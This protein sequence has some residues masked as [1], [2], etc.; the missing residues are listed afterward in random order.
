MEVAKN[1]DT[2]PL[3]ERFQAAHFLIRELTEHLQQAFLPKLSELRSASK[4]D[5]AKEVSDQEIF[6]KLQSTLSADEFSAKIFGRLFRYL[7]SIARDTKEVTGVS[8]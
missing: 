5:D 3:A 2:V 1:P 6:D 7:E 4:V 8:E